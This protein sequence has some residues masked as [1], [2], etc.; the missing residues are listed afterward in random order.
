MR[1]YRRK[2][3]P[4]WWVD[5]RDQNG[6]RHRKST[7]TDDKDLAIALAAKWQQESFMER[8]FGTIPETPFRDALLRYGQEKKRQNPEGYEASTKYRLQ[9]LLDKFDGINL[10]GINLATI[11]DFAD[12]R[13]KQVKDGSVQ[14]E[15]AT[16]KAILN[17][18][19]REERLAAVPPFPRMKA[20]RGRCRWLTVDEEQRLLA[21]AAKHLRPLIAFAI[22][23]GGR[24]SELLKLDWRHVDLERGCVTF[25]KTKNGED[26]S[27]RLTDRAKK[28][29]AELG[30]KPE[31]PV[32]T[33][34]RKR[35]KRVKTSFETAR[36][37]AGIADIRFHDLRHTFASRLVQQ[38]IPLY[39]VMHLTGH[40]TVSMVQRYA[41][42]A[43]DY[44]DRAIQALNR[45]GHKMDTADSNEPA[46]ITS[47][48]LNEMV[49][50][51]GI[52]PGTPAV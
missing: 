33:Y 11:Q 27:V 3:S 31:G 32:F 15:L 4:K 10:S 51:P 22:D 44:Q 19:H 29:L 5:W 37:K 25:T 35:M 39:E 20:L 45:Y 21:S 50:A 47:K 46:A 26:R 12:E 14:K 48:S 30:P 42:L 8:H 16:L 49:G 18:A 17:R 52:E 9:L 41:H 43:P 23:T 1:L 40:K 7:R 13:L 2:G 38:G 24:R 6:Q 34:G 28:V 36:E